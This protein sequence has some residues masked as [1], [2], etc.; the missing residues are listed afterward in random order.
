MSLSPRVS[1]LGANTTA[2]ARLRAAYARLDKANEQVSTTKAY[3]RPSENTSASSRAAVLQDQI[4]QIDSYGRSIDDAKSRLD[5]ADSKASQAMDLYHRITELTTQAASSLNSADSR[6]SIREEVVQL[7][8]ELQSVANFRYLGQPLFGGL[9][10]ADPATFNSGTSTWSFTGA[11]SDKIVRRVGPNETVDA[12]I[13]A[14][15]LFSNS[16]TG[17]IF[18]VLD[19]LSASLAADDTAGIQAALNKVQSLQNT[20]S[21]GQARIGA[22]ASRVDRAATRNS[23]IKVSLTTELSSLEDVDLSTAIT[24][25]NRLSVAYNA[26]LGVTAK[27]QQ[28][29]LLDWLR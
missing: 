15:E 29:T 18:T 1:F 19:G 28:Q 4:D 14:G 23:A 17:D 2:Q 8:G 5:I 25:Q 12:S 13:T 27:A 11:A 26:A 16:T 21:A 3:S 7:Q 9:G 20:L 22:N 10:S 6:L 24:D